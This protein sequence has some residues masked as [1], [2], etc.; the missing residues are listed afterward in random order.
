M[1]DRDSG[2][3]ERLSMSYLAKLQKE[4]RPKWIV[5]L[6]HWCGRIPPAVRF[7]LWTMLG[8]ALLLVPA[9]VDGCFYL[10]KSVHFRH[11]TSYLS[12]GHVPLYIW[13]IYFATLFLVS[14]SISFNLCR[15]SRLTR[16]SLGLHGNVHDHQCRSQPRHLGLLHHCRGSSRRKYQIAHAK[17]ACYPALGLCVPFHVNCVYSHVPHRFARV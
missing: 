4:A 5:F 3:F 11:H 9:I 17:S 12:I 7:Q 8:T 15:T 13:S 10:N 16:P 1:S 2:D 14:I 6:S